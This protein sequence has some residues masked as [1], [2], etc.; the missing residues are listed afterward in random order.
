[1][2]A[3]VIDP[4]GAARDRDLP[5]LSLALDPTSVRKELSQLPRLVGARGHVELNTI[6]VTRHKPGRRCVVEY[7]VVAERA[8][9]P[10]QALT[11][12]GIVR[13]RR[14]GKT[15]YRRLN[16]VWKAGFQSDS[17]DGVSV[18]E[19]LGVVP[20]Y[21]MWFQRKVPGEIC[22]TELLKL[23]GAPLAARMA[24]A[25][26]K[27]HRANVST[28]R[29]HRMEDEL[30]ILRDHVP[31]AARA[32]PEWSGRLA[33]ILS[34]C[35]ALGSSL[36]EAE[37]C[38][39]HRDFYPAQVIV[40][41]PLDRPRVWLL[42]FDLYCRGDPALDIGNFIG[43]IT[44]QSLRTFGNV[45]A[46]EDREQ[47]MENRFVEFAG[48]SRREAVRAYATLTLVRH[49]YLSSRFPERVRLTEQLIEL[50]EGRLRLEQGS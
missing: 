17:P 36:T 24:E 4:F 20:R 30:R 47:A 21:R 50:C 7:D 38:G 43:H 1:M 37:T 22:A 41:R 13:V 31:L 35:D 25:V 15:D 48:E 26:H 8:G 23:D 45:R 40:D 2:R 44:E 49:I 6:Q 3:A 27:L 39:I 5:T 16:A 18:P 12:I 42:D 28:D 9:G 32:K 29:H 46:L 34:A 14:Y 33:R 11:L 19:P 10:P